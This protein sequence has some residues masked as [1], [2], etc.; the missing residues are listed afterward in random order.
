MTSC[1]VCEADGEEFC[2]RCRAAAATMG[3]QRPPMGMT[4][5]GA[6]ELIA[7]VAH[8]DD[9]GKYGTG[10]YVDEH[11]AR[12]ARLAS[13]TAALFTVAPWYAV[14]AAWLHDVEEDTDWNLDRIKWA[15]R[16]ITLHRDAPIVI[17]DA[18][19]RL[20]HPRAVSRYQYILRITAN[21]V[22]RAAKLADTLVNM[23]GID[24]AV[25]EGR[26]DEPTALRLSRK[27]SANLRQLLP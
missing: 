14:P 18:V 7:R 8:G 4:P 9:V 12:V 20:R 23:S 21:P 5:V 3:E 16:R 10:R 13:Q 27:Y 25:T 26:M 22:A 1:V 11:V 24:D 15:F 2:P 19:E 6:A 17:F